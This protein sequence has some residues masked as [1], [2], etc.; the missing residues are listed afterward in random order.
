MTREGIKKLA[1]RVE[2]RIAALG[3]ETPDLVVI[4]VQLDNAV[5]A[6]IE[7]RLPDNASEG[8]VSRRHK[9]EGIAADRAWRKALRGHPEG[10]PVLYLTRLVTAKSEIAVSEAE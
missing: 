7:E 5:I 2:E 8:L 1:A 10:A 9:A 4:D 6:E 3:S